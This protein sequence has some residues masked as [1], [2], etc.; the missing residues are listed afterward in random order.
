M[1]AA[2]P[3][4]NSGKKANILSLKDEMVGNMRPILFIL[5][6][7]V[8]FVLLISCVNVANLLLARSTARQNEFAI[9]IALGAGQHRVIRQLL[10]ESLLLSLIGG[11][12][13]LLVAKFGTTAALAAM[14]RTLPRSDDIGLDPRVLLFTFALSL[15]AGIIFGL[16]PAWKASQGSV[17]RQLIE[18]GRAL[19]GA[20]SSAQSVFVIGELAMALVLL[21]GAGLMI[22]TLMQLWEADPGFQ[23]EE[24]IDSGALWPC[25]LQSWLR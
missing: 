10:T 6:G 1:T 20:H 25:F 7:A 12:L 15:L 11:A 22:R 19:A 8:A 16:M 3:D 5:L 23:S 24:R 4:V 18:S 9:R 17:S 14:P 2:Y 21:I 13:G